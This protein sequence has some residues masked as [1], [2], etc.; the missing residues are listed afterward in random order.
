VELANRPGTERFPHAPQEFRAGPGR[1]A[2]MAI[3]A[4]VVACSSPPPPPPAPPLNVEEVVTSARTR[5]RLQEPARILFEWS[6]TE[7]DARFNGRGV[8]RIEPPY[9]ARLD[10]FLPN[11]ETIA[12]AALVD[13]DL[14]VPAG[15]RDGIIPP[16]HL[17]WG[18]LGVFRPGVGAALL[19]VDEDDGAG[20]QMR[21]GYAGG[22]QILYHLAGQ[23][24]EEVERLEGGHVV[25]QVSL[26]LG[27]DSRYPAEAVY[28]DLAAFRELRITRESVDTVEPYPPDIWDP[29]L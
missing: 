28:R 17:L 16:P 24:V 18:V 3:T 27:S 12:R 10:L 26:V 25:Q 15:V 22:T 4:L 23:R 29:G 20:L 8:A 1:W 14:R 7:P 11:G 13:D 6:L 5:S 19:G 21:Y 9:R 2:A